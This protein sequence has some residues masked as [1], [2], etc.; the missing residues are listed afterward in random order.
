MDLDFIN[1]VTF[2]GEV[3]ATYFFKRTISD[4]RVPNSKYQTGIFPFSTDVTVSPGFNWHFAAKMS[5]Y[6]FLD[7]LSFYFQYLYVHHESDHLFPV[8]ERLCILTRNS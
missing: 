4:F 6:H 3:G 5:A 2:G 8:H 7:R 1:S